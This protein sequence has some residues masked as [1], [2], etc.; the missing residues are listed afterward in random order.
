MNAFKIVMAVFLAH[1]L[2]GVP[3][4]VFGG[5]DLWDDFVKKGLPAAAD[6]PPGN[7]DR[8]AASLARDISWADEQSLPALLT[9]LQIAGFSIVDEKRTVLRKPLDGG[10]GQ[11]LGFYD[12]E[13]VG[14]LRL[15]ARGVS[16][17]LQK[18]AGTII[19]DVPNMTAS[20][21]AE[22]LLT[23]LRTQATNSTDTY[24]RFWAR[25]IIEL[26]KR[27]TPP[28]DLMTAPTN[29]INLS[30]L[31]TSLLIRR[32]QG[33]IAILKKK[34]AQ[35][36]ALQPLFSQSYV[37]PASWKRND[38]PLVQLVTDSSNGALPCN[39][40]GDDG[41]ILDAAANGLTF[42]Q[43]LWMMVL[44]ESLKSKALDRFSKGLAY[45]NMGLA[46]GKL[47]A[48]LTMLKGEIAVDNPPLI[49]TLNSVPGEKRLMT[50]TIRSEVGKKQ[51]VNCF[52]T[53]INIATGLDFDVPSDGPMSDTAVI[54]E[55]KNVLD[56]SKFV[57]LEAPQ[58][59]DRNPFK[60]ATDAKGVSQMLLV[61]AP[62]IP[63]VVKANPR[64]VPKTAH[65]GV[66]VT[67]KSAKDFTQNWI[68][69]GGVALGIVFTAVTKDPLG[70]VGTAVGAASE[71]GYRLPHV[72]ARTAVP[73]IDHEPFL[74]YRY[75][76]N[77]L[78]YI[79]PEYSFSGV[80]CSLEKPFTITGTAYGDKQIHTCQPISPTAGA[81]SYHADS[82]ISDSIDG[83]SSYTIDGADRDTPQILMSYGD[84]VVTDRGGW[85]KV[86]DRIIDSS[87][88][89]N[90]PHKSPWWIPGRGT[91]GWILDLVPLETDECEK[92]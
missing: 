78:G 89:I 49:R 19:K 2:W 70:A 54:W 52:R 56:T 39:L 43:G 45:V 83:S 73:V 3:Q 13:A 68:D 82:K 18:L 87:G 81:C 44:Q 16:I 62:K 91:L 8:Q 51:I 6:L 55:L 22:V 4:T 10:T 29:H 71:I 60:Q 37:V 20:Q 47:V 34:Y 31:Q 24:I 33:D 75:E 79:P 40:A 14:S 76:L 41:L 59:K 32:L 66:S 36:G 85:L 50:A 12:F 84:T 74:G 63:A 64:K 72:V 30:V 92:P 88:L 28:V 57:R 1:A 27:S 38:A 25:L 53:A 86:G 67:L 35:T 9:A 15:Q 21:F 61:G 7:I 69:I 77:R 26:S 42:G 46:W 5:A 58:G 65:V 80:I 90:E 48:S 17:S 11:G 23:D